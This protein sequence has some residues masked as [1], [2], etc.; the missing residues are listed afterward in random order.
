MSNA[1]YPPVARHHPADGLRKTRRIIAE[2]LDW[3][4]ATVP[5][6]SQLCLQSIVQN[7]QERPVFEELSPIEKDF[8]QERLSPSVP[9]GVTA[10]VVSDGV[11]W[12]RCCEQRWDLCDVSNYDHSWKRMFFERHMESIIELFIPDVTDPKTVLDM[13]SLCG[14]YVKRLD[15]SQLLPPIKEPEKEEEKNSSDLASDYEVETPSMDHFDF[16]ILLD[17][18]TCLEKLHLVYRVKQCGMNFVWNMFEMTDR[19]CESLAKALKSCKTLKVLKINQ[20]NIND[21]LCR[22]LVKNLLDHPSL[23]ELDFSHNLIGDRGARALG[24]LLSNSKLEILNLCD[25]DIRDPGAKAIAHALSKNSTLLFLSLRLNRLSDEGGKAIG[26]ALLKNN[27]L[28]QLHLGA[29]RVTGPTAVALSKALAQNN[30]LKSI[31]LSCNNLG[32]IRVE[33]VQ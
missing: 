14:N 5:S 26:Q 13:V 3:V 19:D 4:L 23:R 29:N 32:E 24:K 6:L 25:N 33:N 17:K 15:I 8:I 1:P 16:S 10:N 30:T 28:L 12:K 11:Y 2:D 20:S 31:N 22:R 7:F 21:N 27:T 18:L 9:L